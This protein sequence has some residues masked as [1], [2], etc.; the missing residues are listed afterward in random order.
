MRL[1]PFLIAVSLALAVPLLGGCAAAV[2]GGVALG[3][4]AAHDRR[5]ASSYIDDKRIYLA[6]YDNIN[7]D[8]ELALKNS[9]IIVVYDGVILLVGEVRTQ[10]LKVRAEQ[11]VSGFEGTVRIINELEIREPEGWWSR[12]ADN[13][14]TARVK[15]GLL[16]ITSLPGFDPTRVNVTTAHRVVYLLG[17]VSHEEGEA[18]TEVARN[19]PDVEKVVTFFDY[20]EP[21]K[22]P[23]EAA[24]P[25]K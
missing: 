3:A 4:G 19:T 18:V 11:R 16:D 15:T 22:E 10:E 5:G 13:S 2:V 9:V 25:Q 8:K 12:R 24:A 17:Y 6:A 14:L 7:K 23:A 20:E 1:H 21:T